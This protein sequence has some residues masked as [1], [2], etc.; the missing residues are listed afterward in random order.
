MEECAR[1][2]GHT[3]GCV[4]VLY[5]PVHRR[6]IVHCVPS[7]RWARKDG[8]L[9]GAE[10]SGA[11]RRGEPSLENGKNRGRPRPAKC[12]GAATINDRRAK[13][14]LC[15]HLG[16]TA[17]SFLS[18]LRADRRRNTPAHSS[19]RCER[20]NCDW[21]VRLV[22]SL[23]GRRRSSRRC[24]R[25]L[26]NVYRA[27]FRLNDEFK[28]NKYIDDV[29]GFRCCKRRPERRLNLLRQI[30][31]REWKGCLEDTRRK[32]WTI[33]KCESSKIRLV[34]GAVNVSRAWS[35]FFIEFKLRG[36]GGCLEETSLLGRSL[37]GAVNSCSDK[38]F[39][40]H[41]GCER[42]YRR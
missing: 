15:F 26:R 23:D 12:F 18:D 32:G 19:P 41:A 13:I 37:L 40:L 1:V 11:A 20:I 29:I 21:F 35:G 28:K 2:H 24:L 3:D 14:V 4:S 30:E 25:F 27:F 9:R 17:R 5:A 42:V 6:W 38:I 22:D 36:W 7:D 31:F 39:A 16:Q 34:S 10:R 8:R 33:V